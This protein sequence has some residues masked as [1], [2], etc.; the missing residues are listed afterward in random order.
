MPILI[1]NG[2][3]ISSERGMNRLERR[4]SPRLK[5]IG[6]HIIYKLNK[7]RYSLKLLHDMTIS[8]ARFEV[9]HKV[10]LG[11]F[12]ELIIIIPKKERIYIKG[13]VFA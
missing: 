11:E 3:L 1:K 2:S 4:Q 9:D 6:A 12:I 5:L 13:K 8:H 7:G 10:E